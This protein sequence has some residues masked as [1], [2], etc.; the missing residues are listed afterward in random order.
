MRYDDI[1]HRTFIASINGILANPTNKDVSASTVVEQ[2]WNIA[3]LAAARALNASTLISMVF[4]SVAS[5]T[6]IAD[7]AVSV[8]GN[9]DTVNNPTAGRVRTQNPTNV[10]TPGGDYVDRR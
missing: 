5:T 7:P 1:L 3:V 4:T 9:D 10:I 6:A 2:S 8:G